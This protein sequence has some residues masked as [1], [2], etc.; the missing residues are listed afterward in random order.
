M[1]LSKLFVN[2]QKSRNPYDIH[3]ELWKLFPYRPDGNRDFLFRL[4]G[5][6]KGSGNEI[7][8]QSIHRPINSD[9]ACHIEANR[10]YNLLLKKGQRLRF[11]LRANPTKKIIDQKGRLNKAGEIK[12][13]RVPLI[14]EDEQKVW[15]DRKLENTCSLNAVKMRPEVP[16]YFH[17]DKEQ[18]S[19]KILTV[20]FDGIIEIINPNAFVDIMRIGIGPAKAFGCGLVSLANA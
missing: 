11:R 6:R 18:S 8:M 5:H 13:C 2:W 16:I 14:R 15:L 17:K 9:S 12:K 7:L 20:L 4:E 10:E 3:R 1:Y 19:G